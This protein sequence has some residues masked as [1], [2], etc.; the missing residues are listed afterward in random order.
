MKKI[1]SICGRLYQ[2]FEEEF[3]TLKYCIKFFKLCSIF[4]DLR[5]TML[6]KSLEEGWESNLKA[7]LEALKLFLTSSDSIGLINFHLLGHSGR[8]CKKYNM[9]LGALGCDS[10]IESYHSHIMTQIEP[11]LG[12]APKSIDNA[13]AYNKENKPPEHM[14]EYYKNLFGRA[15]EISLH[16]IDQKEVKKTHFDYS[17]NLTIDRNFVQNFLNEL[18]LK[19][20]HF[21]LKKKSPKFDTNIKI[22]LETPLIV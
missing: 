20:P 8:I 1:L 18:H 2:I 9:G 13:L 22:Y 3:S 5:K 15:L 4:E 14:T 19:G 7:F 17:K 21:Q 11:H 16:E 10:Q 12:K 6:C